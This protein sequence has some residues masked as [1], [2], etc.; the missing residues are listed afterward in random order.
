MCCCFA[1]A[2]TS[3][4]KCK[5]CASGAGFRNL[6]ATWVGPA[7]LAQSCT[8]DTC[9]SEPCHLVSSPPCHNLLPLLAADHQLIE[10][11]QTSEANLEEEARR[12][13]RRFQTDLRAEKLKS[14]DRCKA[15]ETL[16]QGV[17]D[18]SSR[19]CF[20]EQYIQLL[21]AHIQQRKTCASSACDKQCLHYDCD[22]SSRHQ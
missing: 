1:A 13:Q 8:C 11:L 4:R 18:I 2:L 9:I 5:L 22:F 6:A 7:T 16:K 14:E 17:L 21:E 3:V 10:Q 19:D 12:I 15:I 20:K